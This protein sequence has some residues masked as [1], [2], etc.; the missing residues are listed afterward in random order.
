MLSALMETCRRGSSSLFRSMQ[1]Q[2]DSRLGLAPIQSDTAYCQRVIPHLPYMSFYASY[3]PGYSGFYFGFLFSLVFM[4]PLQSPLP[5][6]TFL[7]PN[8]Y[9]FHPFLYLTFHP[10]P[11]LSHHGNTSELHTP[12]LSSP[13]YPTA[14][15]TTPDTQNP[16]SSVLS[17]F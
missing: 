6:N 11:T 1:T 9:R 13:S 4:A 17:S 10:P 3:A 7:P 12:D 8:S 5:S 2:H 14:P 16:T 15:V